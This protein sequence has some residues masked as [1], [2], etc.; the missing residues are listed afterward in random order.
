MRVALTRHVAHRAPAATAERHE[1]L[2]LGHYR[3]A[4]RVLLTLPAAGGGS[5]EQPH[6]V[7]LVNTHLHHGGPTPA[8]QA[9]LARDV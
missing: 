6:R 9:R 2:P 4:Q 1:T 3:A 5:T 8:E 7:W